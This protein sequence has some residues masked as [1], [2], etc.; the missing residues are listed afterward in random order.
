M[1]VSTISPAGWNVWRQ[2]LAGRLRGLLHVA[3]GHD[4]AWRVP[5]E[6]PRRCPGDIVCED[7]ATVL[8]CRSQDPWRVPADTAVGRETRPDGMFASVATLEQCH[9]LLRLADACRGGPAGDEI[10][11]VCCE[12]I[13]SDGMMRKACGRRLRQA[14]LRI[15]RRHSRGCAR[16]DDPGLS[17]VRAFTGALNAMLH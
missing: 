3:R 5:S 9:D 15:E 12:L 1:T 10:R 16:D 17:E 4:V 7:C 2:A 13:E 11:R 8:W 14:L 6:D